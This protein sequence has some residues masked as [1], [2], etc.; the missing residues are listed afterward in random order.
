[1]ECLRTLNTSPSFT[2]D[3]V[4]FIILINGINQLELSIGIME[5]CI[6]I[7]IVKSTD[8]IKNKY[9]IHKIELYKSMCTKLITNK[10]SGCAVLN[11]KIIYALKK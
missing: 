7:H 1:M 9:G 11:G 4:K 6:Y 8:F 5:Y 2:S 10:I 3:Q